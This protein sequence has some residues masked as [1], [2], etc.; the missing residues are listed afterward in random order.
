MLLTQTI[1]SS[2]RVVSRQF[3]RQTRRS[4]PKAVTS[5]YFHDTPILSEKAFLFPDKDESLETV[6]KTQFHLPQRL[7]HKILSAEDAVTLVRNKA[8]IA[9][10]GFVCQGK[11]E[12][13]TSLSFAIAV[14]YY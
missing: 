11:K 9:V 8:T 14:L 6:P 10:T 7:R 13:R 3:L 4:L 2:S 12:L 5:R 1:R